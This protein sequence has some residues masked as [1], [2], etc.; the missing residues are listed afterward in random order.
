MSKLD[1]SAVIARLN[2]MT[3]VA[4]DDAILTPD[5][6]LMALVRRVDALADDV[7]AGLFDSDDGAQ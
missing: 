1:I 6:A 3:A 2:R 5:T 4:R 7:A